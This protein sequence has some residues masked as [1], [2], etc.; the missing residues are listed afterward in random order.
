MPEQCFDIVFHGE[1]APGIPREVVA[2][3]LAQLFR[4]TP[5]TVARLLDGSTHTLK[6]GLDAAAAERY[7]SALERAGAV[8]TLQP[9]P[10]VPATAPAPASPE[11]GLA[12]VGSD[13]LAPH[14]RRQITATAPDTSHIGLNA[15]GTRLSPPGPVPPEPP[16]TSHLTLAPAGSVL[17]EP[18]AVAAGVQPDISAL[19]LLPPA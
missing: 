2:G 11:L 19:E 9:A 6:R 10:A 12:P 16:D 8:V 15:A 17:A 1:T 13:V 5:D 7:R 14:E 4:T 18:R 3:N